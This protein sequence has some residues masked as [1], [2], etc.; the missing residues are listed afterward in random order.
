[1]ITKENALRRLSIRA[2]VIL[3]A[4]M[5]IAL[6]FVTI[7]AYTYYSRLLEV[8]EKLAEHGKVIASVIADTSDYSM[9]S[10]NYADIDRLIRNIVGKDDEIY[11]I[12]ILD[13]NRKEIVKAGASS[14]GKWSGKIIEVPIRSI[15]ILAF[16]DEGMPD[17]SEPRY[18][19]M[20]ADNAAAPGKV[21][22][23]VQIMVSSAKVMQKQ[24]ERIAIQFGVALGLF[25]CSVLF[26]LWLSRSITRPM[27][28]AI[29]VL[30]AI[31]NGDYSMRSAVSTGG[32][33]GDLQSTI[34]TM[35]DNLAEA[36]QELENKVLART[37]ELEKSRNE[38]LKADAEKRRLIQKV[39]QVVEDE[40]KSISGE[41]HDELN[42]T[43]IG[44]RLNA[45]R[46]ADVTET[47]GPSISSDEISERTQSIIKMASSLYA[48]ARRIIRR[49]RPE[50][51]D[52]LGLQGAVQEIVNGYN[53]A[54]QQ[55]KF[56]LVA[57]GDF[58]M[59]KGVSGIAAYRLVQEALSNIIKHANATL[60]TVTLILDEDEDEKAL[61][62][63][64]VDNGSG[65]DVSATTLGIG[66]IGMRERV[67]A[68]NGQMKINSTPGGGTEISIRLP[69]PRNSE[70]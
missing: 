55:C 21:H 70:L 37:K 46:I 68:F 12:T 35:A 26:G 44:I 42:A 9:T 62:I 25:V 65:F 52:M 29:D 69:V 15:P 34:N 31:R 20:L 4:T 30:R 23:Y 18:S 61:Y 60:A 45:Q 63:T 8:E 16:P 3:I 27:S 47:L 28:M 41:I 38:A 1:M 11:S 33:I 66:I 22:G 48:S 50:V 10:G 43:L 36:R 13:T 40:R 67:Y 19:P 39:D 58:S 17:V 54:Y 14:K 53:S 2:R 24:K 56:T 7:A 64:I 5:P 49:L 6:M 32:E 57:S 51:L 59:L